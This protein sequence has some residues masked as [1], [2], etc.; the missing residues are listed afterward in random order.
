MNTLGK[1]CST[2]SRLLHCYFDKNLREFNIGSGQQFCLL[3]IME[4]PGTNCKMISEKGHFDLATI[5]R[6]TQKLES[7]GYVN[8]IVDEKDKRIKKLYITESGKI[9]AKVTN[10][11]INEY[12]NFL[13]SEIPEKEIDKTI[14]LLDLVI[15]KTLNFLDK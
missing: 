7:L 11:V 2:L 1:N 3:K 9:V 5:L 4:N 14:Q 13:K 15:E 8:S 10:N 6:A 12:Y